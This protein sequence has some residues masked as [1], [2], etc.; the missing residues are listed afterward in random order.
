MAPE[1]ARDATQASP[2][3]DIF[4]L[5]ATMV[6]AATGHPP[7]RGE[8]VMDI[9]VRLATEPPDLA[10][11]PDELAELVGACLERVP[12]DRPSDAAIL[13]ELGP[14]EHLAAEPGHSYLPDS[15]MAL[16]GEYQRSPSL[17][18]GG[19]SARWRRRRR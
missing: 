4:S 5:G 13:A 14:F 8:T 2:A 19:A 1:Q 9:L 11:M 3:S 16:I 7:Y 12:R 18:A 10:G 17:P 15:A 6:F